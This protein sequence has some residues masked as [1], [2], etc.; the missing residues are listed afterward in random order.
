MD[1]IKNRRVIF[2]EETFIWLD[3]KIG[4]LI[5]IQNKVI[6][7]CNKKKLL[8]KNLVFFVDSGSFIKLMYV[9]FKFS[10]SQSKLISSEALW[11]VSKSQRKRYSQKSLFQFNSISQEKFQS[12]IQ[13]LT[14]KKTRLQFFL[15]IRLCLFFIY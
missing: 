11:K 4:S 13:M 5:F 6:W 9:C 10:G 1:L 2:Y 7:L 12:E 14:S 3:N 15:F 8:V